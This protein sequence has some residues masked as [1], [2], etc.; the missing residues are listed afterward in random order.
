[1]PSEER[2]QYYRAFKA[3]N[4]NNDM[5]QPRILTALQ[6]VVAAMEET[7]STD[8]YDIAVALEDMRFTTISGEEIWMR[9]EDHQVVQGL[10]LSVPYRPGRRIRC[11]Q[12]WIWTGNKV[13]GTS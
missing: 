10:H 12:L 3:E 5:T 11:R 8:P 2:K 1:L 13:F 9:G 6:M 7:Q 4:P